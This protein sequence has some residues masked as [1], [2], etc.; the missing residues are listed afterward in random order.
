MFNTCLQF[1]VLTRKWKA[2]L[3]DEDNDPYKKKTFFVISW[4][5]MESKEIDTPNLHQNFQ[6]FNENQ[7]QS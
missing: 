1:W 5:Q 4:E 6:D 3:I 2:K 7:W